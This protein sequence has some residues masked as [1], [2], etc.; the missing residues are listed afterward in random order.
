M[1]L[2][3]LAEHWHALDPKT[4]AEFRAR[5]GKALHQARQLRLISAQHEP[6]SEERP[7]ERSRA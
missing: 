4:A 5:A 1:L 6:L 3:H 7:Q 2:T